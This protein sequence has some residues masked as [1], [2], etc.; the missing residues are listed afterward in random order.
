MKATQAV[1]ASTLLISALLSIWIV[2]SDAWL[3][4]VAPTHEYGLLAFAAID[5]FLAMI[6]FVAPRVADV[7][8]FLLAIIQAIA[9]LGDVYNFAPTGTMQAAFRTYLLADVQFVGLFVI[10]LA[11]ASIASIAMVSSHQLTRRMHTVGTPRL[12]LT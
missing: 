1:L 9:M 2:A 8:T 3:R 10:Q 7:C 11:L 5:L 6:L 4:A 12:R